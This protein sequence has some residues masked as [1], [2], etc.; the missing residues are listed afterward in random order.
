MLT[1]ISPNAAA[2][3]QAATTAPAAR[4]AATA[5]SLSASRATAQDTVT[6]SSA[7]QQA[8]HAAGDV[9]HDGDSH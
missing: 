3:P 6:I 9:N 2:A 1:A 7:G 8:A 5:A 4:S